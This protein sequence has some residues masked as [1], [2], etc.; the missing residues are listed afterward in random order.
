MPRR[1]FS[2]DP[3]ANGGMLCCTML[4]SD[5]DPQVAATAKRSHFAWSP[6]PDTVVT[7]Q[8]FGAA[9]HVEREA[10]DIYFMPSSR[11]KVVDRAFTNASGA[12]EVRDELFIN[13][14]ECQRRGVWNSC[15]VELLLRASLGCPGWVAV[16]R[17]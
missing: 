8:F 9:K 7:K 1:A 5:V 12:R 14:V 3:K 17:G 4:G 16:W 15:E 6:Q 2:V 13:Y 11:T 10:N